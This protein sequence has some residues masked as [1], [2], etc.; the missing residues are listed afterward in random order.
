MLICE[1][2]WNQLVH[3]ISWVERRA[4]EIVLRNT[5]CCR[6]MYFQTRVVE[7]KCIRG[8]PSMASTDLLWSVVAR[9]NLFFK[10]SDVPCFFWSFNTS[11][12]RISRQ[13]EQYPLTRHPGWFPDATWSFEI[14]QSDNQI[15]NF[16]HA[17]NFEFW[18]A[19]AQPPPITM[20]WR[21]KHPLTA[22][23]SRLR[24][25]RVSHRS[26]LKSHEKTQ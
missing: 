4:T 25:L 21:S 9:Q 20:S 1:T 14:Y 5:C 3:G 11:S 7:K 6:T 16:C 17:K 2:L 23:V 8:W 13:N 24:W 15:I 19:P 26:C 18:Q 12:C 10:H 22:D